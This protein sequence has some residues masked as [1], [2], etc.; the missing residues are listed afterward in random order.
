[1]QTYTYI[2]S[3]KES[4]KYLTA[5]LSE[6]E[7]A[8]NATVRRGKADANYIIMADFGDDEKA[9]ADTY[10]SEMGLEFACLPTM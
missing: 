5:H 3:D 7:V 8:F 9:A 1:M 10:I 2:T 4:Y 6:D